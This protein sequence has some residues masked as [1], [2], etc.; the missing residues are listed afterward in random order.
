MDGS[1]EINL[2]VPSI[3]RL[4]ARGYGG[5]TCRF[6]VSYTATRPVVTVFARVFGSRERATTV[7]G[8]RVGSGARLCA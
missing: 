3:R 2:R 8:R 1:L 5:I 4:P 7:D 6:R